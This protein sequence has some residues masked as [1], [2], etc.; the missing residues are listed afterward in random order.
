MQRVYKEKEW[1]KV[2]KIIVTMGQSNCKLLKMV[3][4]V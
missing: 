4:N 2:S 3:K 1:G